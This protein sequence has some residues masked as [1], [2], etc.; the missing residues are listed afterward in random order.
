M[1]HGE[2]RPLR[3][4]RLEDLGRR[5]VSLGRAQHQ[6]GAALPEVIERV[7]VADAMRMFV[8]HVG[9][10]GGARARQHLMAVGIV[11]RG[12]GAD[13]MHAQSVGDRRRALLQRAQSGQEGIEHDEARRQQRAG[14]DHVEAAVGRIEQERRAVHGAHQGE[15]LGRAAH[16]HG[17]DDGV[18]RD[19]GIA[20]EHAR[21]IAR[22]HA[23]DQRGAL[24]RPRFEPGRQGV[25]APGAREL[26]LDARPVGD[27]R[28][29]VID[30]ERHAEAAMDQ[31]AERREEVRRDGHH[32]EVGRA[33]AHQ[34]CDRPV[35]AP[36]GADADVADQRLMRQGRRVHHLEAGRDQAQEIRIGPL[37]V[38]ARIAGDHDRLPAELR[39]VARP[40]P[41]AMAA[42]QVAGREVAARE[43]EA[44]GHAAFLATSRV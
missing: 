1:Q 31:P 11:G 42:D 7:D 20:L 10:A 4:D 33:L 21:D 41:R 12:A 34:L 37:L 38:V 14:I 29:L 18:L 39:Q 30:A 2:H 5:V 24:H 23:G 9:H 44:A 17:G 36:E 27:P 25:G 22:R 35:G 15:I 19:L 3:Q 13:E 26:A 43:D 6:H 40:Q 28:I 32:H 8:D 16:R